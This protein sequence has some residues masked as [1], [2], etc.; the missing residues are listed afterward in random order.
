[1]TDFCAVLQACFFFM[2]STPVPSIKAS[3]GNTRSCLTLESHGGEVEGI[4]CM[5]SCGGD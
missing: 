3:R 5:L 1:V 2:S 4:L